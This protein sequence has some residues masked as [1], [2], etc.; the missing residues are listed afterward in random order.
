MHAANEFVLPTVT[1]SSPSLPDDQSAVAES[2]SQSSIP[3]S[4]NDASHHHSPQMDSTGDWVLSDAEARC[5]REREQVA[6]GSA[7]AN[8]AEYS[9]WANAS[10]ANIYDAAG[11]ATT[12]TENAEILEFQ[13]RDSEAEAAWSTGS[14]RDAYD[15]WKNTPL[16]AHWT[17]SDNTSSTGSSSSFTDYGFGQ[18]SG[19]DPYGYAP[20]DAPP[21][22][23]TAEDYQYPPPFDEYF[24]DVPPDDDVDA[25]EFMRMVEAST[26]FPPAHARHPHQ[27]DA[28]I[29]KNL[30]SWTDGICAHQYLL[31][32]NEILAAA[33]P[34]REFRQA[35]YYG[36]SS[37]HSDFEAMTREGDRRFREA[38]E[39]LND[40]HAAFPAPIRPQPHPIPQATMFRTYLV[41]R[42]GVQVPSNS[43]ISAPQDA[44]EA[45]AGLCTSSRPLKRKSRDDSP[46]TDG[47]DSEAANRRVSKSFPTNYTQVPTIQELA[48]GR[49]L[50]RRGMDSIQGALVSLQSDFCFGRE[51]YDELQRKLQQFAVD[52]HT[53]LP[54]HDGH[55]RF[56]HPL[57]T[58]E[59][60]AKFHIYL[61]LLIHQRL[62]YLA[63]LV[64]DCLR[65]QFRE[66]TAVKFLLTGGYLDTYADSDESSSGSDIFGSSSTDSNADDEPYQFSPDAHANVEIVVD[67][68]QVSDTDVD[69]HR[70]K[71]IAAFTTPGFRA[72]SLLPT[73]KSQSIDTSSYGEDSKALFAQWDHANSV[74]MAD[75][76]L[77]GSVPTVYIDPRLLTDPVAVGSYLPDRHY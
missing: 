51:R 73:N 6:A 5:L 37:R 8:S 21:P 61:I 57:L 65:V 74:A 52:Y 54:Q 47:S 38:T 16:P 19:D 22:L 66:R 24:A 59:E 4:H 76:D 26:G 7:A 20:V 28:V 2:L 62:Y 33:L 43:S 27:S 34:L 48:H 44:N 64:F 1:H 49:R 60:T 56:S 23:P 9:S 10:W 40:V 3:A 77:L 72:Q 13:R 70:D 69:Q 46:S 41:T 71:R 36:T 75:V 15:D 67:H 11:A 45:G 58:D 63:A 39:G 31:R 32:E 42:G 68:P 50:L 25:V 35:Y 18:T 53:R 30:G 17:T 12:T 14:T 55:R 29:N